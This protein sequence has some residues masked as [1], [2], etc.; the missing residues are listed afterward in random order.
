MERAGGQSLLKRLELSCWE[1]GRLTAGI[2]FRTGGKKKF[3]T[4]GVWNEQ[5]VYRGRLRKSVLPNKTCCG[6]LHVAYVILDS[7]GGFTMSSRSTLRTTI[8]YAERSST[9]AKVQVWFT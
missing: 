4:G 3:L 5:V 6:W 7:K 9:S 8:F 1:L 2:L